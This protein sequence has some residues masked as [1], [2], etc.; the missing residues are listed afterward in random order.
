MKQ[1]YTE[2]DVNTLYNLLGMS[3]WHLQHLE[4]ILTTFTTLVILH[5]KVKNGEKITEKDKEE[6]LQKQQKLTLGPL[7]GSS[8]KE[9]TIP[10][11]LYN[12]F[13][14]FLSERNWVI[15]KCVINE[16]LS[17]RNEKNKEKLFERISNFANDAQALTKEMYILHESW[18]E[19]RGY[20]L[21][22]AH[23][24][25]EKILNEAEKSYRDRDAHR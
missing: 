25:A 19:K 21:K 23:M 1:P 5:K 11:E 6:F 15:H 17:L 20:N 24:K 10:K 18:F 12:R 13:E 4:N 7:I 16:Y 22:A 14:K 2:K 9:K 3:V 8:K